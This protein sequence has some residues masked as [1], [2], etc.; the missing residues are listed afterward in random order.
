MCPTAEEPVPGWVDNFNGP[1]GLIIGGATG[2]MRFNNDSPDIVW[3][4]IVSKLRL[5][6]SGFSLMK[7]HSIKQPVD[8]V[9]R[10]IILSSWKE[11]NSKKDLSQDVP[12]Y[13]SASNGKCKYKKRI[14]NERVS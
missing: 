13:N 7:F 6:L 1:I 9:A 10:S 11:A 12:I 2:I 3:D 8:T 4:Y 14:E 5:C